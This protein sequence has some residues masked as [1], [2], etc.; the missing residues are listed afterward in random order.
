[1]KITKKNQIEDKHKLTSVNKTV[2]IICQ[3]IDGIKQDCP[4]NSEQTNDLK[5]HIS[6]TTEKLGR[7]ENSANRQ[8]QYSQHNC[9]L[10]HRVQEG[11]DA[12]TAQL[13]LETVRKSWKLSGYQILI[14][15]AGL[16]QRKETTK[17]S[18]KKIG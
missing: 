3:K 18:R 10:I 9:I 7:L 14:E 4:E 6:L 16:D 15:R 5:K 13:V 11:H 17:R 1:M 2:T 8:Q 12:N